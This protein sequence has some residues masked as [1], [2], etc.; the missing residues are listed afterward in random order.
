MADVTKVSIANMALDYLGQAS[1]TSLDPP[2]TELEG[3]VDRHYDAVRRACLREYQ[4]NFAKRRKVL[5]SSG[6]PTFDYA[7]TYTMPNDCLR[8][9][10]ITDMTGAFDILDYDVEGRDIVVN[11]AA[12]GLRLRYIADVTDVAL[13]DALFVQYFA[14]KL[15][16]KL[17]YK[18]SLKKSLIDMLN[19]MI[20]FEE[21]KASSIDGQERVPEQ[22]PQRSSLL[23]ARKG[24]GYGYSGSRDTRYY[25]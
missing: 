20:P 7:T 3:T 24:Y 15:A 6:T 14:L 21:I 8:I 10:S 22:L 16:I 2:A 19:A 5:A 1:V 18:L 9:I 12:T 23:E 11:G 13:Y 4:W 17:A 25:P